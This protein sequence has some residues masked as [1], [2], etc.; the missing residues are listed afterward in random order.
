MFWN[1]RN[2]VLFLCEKLAILP[3]NGRNG[4]STV[5]NLFQLL[6]LLRRFRQILRRVLLGSGGKFFTATKWPF[7]S[8]SAKACV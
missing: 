8:A 3:S 7:K 1:H 6:A 5:L 2:I 4:I